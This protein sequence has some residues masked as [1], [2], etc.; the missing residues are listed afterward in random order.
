MAIYTPQSLGITTPSGGFQTGGWYSGRQYWNGTLSD[1]GVE[2]PESSS[3]TAGKTVSA[4]VNAASAAA[5]GVSAQQLESY[6]AGQRKTSANVTPTTATP[7]TTGTGTT[8][9]SGTSALS[10]LATATQ[11]TLNLPELYQSLYNSSGVSDIEAELLTKTKAYNTAISKI[12]NNPYLSEAT[13]TGRISKMDEKYNADVAALK[14]DIAT[15]KADI[16]TQINLQT[17]QYDINSEQ[18][19]LALSQFNSLLESG[20][21]DNVSGEDIANLT[22]STGLSSTIIQSAINA[23]KTE[24]LSIEIK[25]F[26]DGVNEGFIIYAID[27]QGNI[28]NETKTITGSSSG[29]SGNYSNDAIVNAF[30]ENYSTGKTDIS[31]NW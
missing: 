24:N 2:H 7:S 30:L 18:A 29:S 6:L 3:A 21:L 19:Q 27:Q 22:R 25:S 31:S 14:N 26:D 1:P 20:A 11:A 12:K 8:G 28:V 4:E 10:G 9:A 16:E 13:M 23:R 15:R 5:Q 17:K